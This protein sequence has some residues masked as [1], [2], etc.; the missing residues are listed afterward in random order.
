MFIEFVRA[1]VLAC[2]LT[3]LLSLGSLSSADTAW[4]E[5]PTQF[6]NDSRVVA[7]PVLR[8]CDGTSR[9]PTQFLYP[10]SR[11]TGP[12]TRT[13]LIDHS[14]QEYELVALSNLSFCCKSNY[15]AVMLK[16]TDVKAKDDEARYL[17]QMF[18]D[19]TLSK[20]DCTSFYP[21]NTCA[22]CAYAYRSWICAQLFPLACL[23]INGRGQVMPI[24]E[25]VCLEVMRKC[26]STLG[27]VCPTIVGN[28]YGPPVPT[29]TF[30]N[31]STFGALGC[32][33]MQ[34]DVAASVGVGSALAKSHGNVNRVSAPLGLL[35][36]LA[37]TLSVLV[38]W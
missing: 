25:T 36:C 3:V 28:V 6:A 31:G 17:Y 37:V 1:F 38:R 14:Q 21:L 5:D 20:Y 34:Y 12:T 19:G 15:T 27:F 11:C 8:Y 18:V 13:P 10:S 22:P 7:S 29:D 33:P 23:D 24:C 35:M 16:G 4:F 32:N 26:P 2:V 30:V 9:L